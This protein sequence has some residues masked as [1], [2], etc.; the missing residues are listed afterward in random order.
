MAPVMPS[1]CQGCCFVPCLTASIGC[2]SAAPS[3]VEARR[4]AARSSRGRPDRVS[5]RSPRPGVSRLSSTRMPMMALLREGVAVEQ[6]GSR[7]GSP[8]PG[9]RRRR[10]T[11]SPSVVV[12]GVHDLRRPPSCAPAAAKPPVAVERG[13]L[14]LERASG[15]TWKIARCSASAWLRSMTGPRQLEDGDD[16]QAAQRRRCRPS[17]GTSARRRGARPA[18][19]ARARRRSCAPSPRGRAVD[20]RP[21]QAVDVRR[22]P[23]CRAGSR[24][25]RP[26]ACRP[27]RGSPRR[28]RRSARRRARSRARSSASRPCRS[29]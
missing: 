20:A 14:A 29:P 1:T 28:A 21:D 19:G 6:R 27:R 23:R 2:A 12:A 7:P 11:S 4:R 3:S 13:R 5:I 25:S 18:A 9:P 26:R 15:S 16:Q 22:R 24:T 17:R 10:P 8:C